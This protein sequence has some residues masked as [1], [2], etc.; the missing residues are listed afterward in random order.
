[1]RMYVW[2][3][4]TPFRD[5]DLEAGIV[6][7]ELSHGLSTRLTGG[8]ANSGCLGWGE[9]GGMGEGW[10][11]FLATVIRSTSTYSD[12]PMGAWAANRDKG[13]RNYV[14]STVSG[15]LGWPALKRLLTISRRTSTEHDHQPFGLQ[16]P[17][18]TW[19][20]GCPRH[21]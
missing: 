16:D 12:Y 7:H 6:I 13:I 20:L 14:Y 15:Q 1:M 11:D 19:L 5:G 9:S 10:G 8:P 17:R 3:T 2:D 18:W 21:W 4:A